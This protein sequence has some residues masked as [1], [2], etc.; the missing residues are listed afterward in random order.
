MDVA[1][2]RTIL[3]TVLAGAVLAFLSGC[4]GGS[5]APPAPPASAT[6]SIQ[7]LDFDLDDGLTLDTAWGLA[8]LTYPTVPSRPVLYFSMTLDGR[9][10]IRNVPVRA[11]G[12][13]GEFHTI[14]LP[15]DLGVAD[16]T[17][18]TQGLV[19]AFLSESVRAAAPLGVQSGNLESLETL[20]EI[21]DGSVLVRTG[22]EGETYEYV[23][24]SDRSWIVDQDVVRH[25][26]H[27]WTRIVN[28]DCAENECMPVAVSNSL[29]MLKRIH[30]TSLKHL[31]DDPTR[32]DDDT[33][34]GTIAPLVGWGMFGAP[35]GDGTTADP[36]AC[37]NKKA[38]AMSADPR[39]PIE[40]TVI[41]D[42]AKMDE[43]IGALNAGKDVEMV[44]P[45]HVVMITGMAKLAD[46][47]YVL[48]VA[49][50]TAQGKPGGTMISAALYDPA[51]NEF[52]GHWA[53]A[54]WGMPKPGEGKPLFMIEEV[55]ASEVPP[56]Y[57]LSPE[58]GLEFE[59]QVGSSPCPQEIG[60]I[61]VQNTGD[62]VVE[63]VV[64]TTHSA[65]DVSTTRTIQGPG[66]T[67]TIRVLFNCSQNSGSVSGSV[68][69]TITGTDSGSVAVESVPVAG[70]VQ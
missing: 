65:L 50:D 69:L 20:A 46:G 31:T 48:E 8:T 39:Y 55:A 14:A 33:D 30:E 68:E 1:P 24:V 61:T 45:G 21:V 12:A 47:R 63:I 27:P 13:P 16:G 18:V 56:S 42:A 51:S 35:V 2:C 34:I 6:L 52:T 10:V 11:G 38:S 37:W 60:A 53:L 29:K 23:P 28:Q 15:F 5:E 36:E 66:E 58:G 3:P 44:V 41:D 7:Q 57:T 19:S 59:H 22:L 62:E 25:G 17:K 54:G 26:F 40:T 67:A 4:G 64:R 49:D 70:A 9:E 43:I 32:T